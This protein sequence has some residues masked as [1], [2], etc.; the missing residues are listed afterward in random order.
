MPHEVER[1]GT[2][3]ELHRHAEAQRRATRHAGAHHLRAQAEEQFM[4]VG[5]P[6]RGQSAFGRNRDGRSWPGIGGDI[7]LVFAGL[8]TDEG[9]PLSVG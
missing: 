4:A 5:R 1:V 9:H 6:D 3:E 8:V 2:V 7:D